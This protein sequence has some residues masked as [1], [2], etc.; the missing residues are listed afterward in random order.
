MKKKSYIDIS[1]MVSEKSAVFPGDKRFKRSISLSF[2]KGNHLLLSSITTT[3]HIG[4]HAD[5]PNH[6][7]K[8]GKSICERDLWPYFGCCQ[9]IKVKTK[10]GARVLP[11]DLPKNFKITEE[12]LLI[13]TDS[14]KNPNQWQKSFCSLSPDLVE[15]CAS[16][17]VKLIGIDTPSI[18]P[19]DSKELESHKAVYKYDLSIIEG[20]TLLKVPN[21]KYLL[22]A[23]PLAI[24][25][26][27]ASPV[28]AVLFP[29]SLV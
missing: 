11:K 23:L 5:A 25:G 28:R 10:P 29:Y 4:A 18:D 1:P 27:D 21:G 14:F 2:K 17:G 26:A 3:L 20:L 6:Y 13:R 24:S 16:K 9:V 7:N 15:F 19:A 12:R 8:K 22:T